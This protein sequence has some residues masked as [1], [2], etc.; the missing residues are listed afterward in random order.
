MGR[1]RIYELA[2][3]LEMSNADLVHKAQSLGL[4]VTNHM[5][6][7]EPD[8]AMRLKRAVEMERRGSVVEKRIGS[9]II[10]R[11]VKR[12]E[13]EAKAAAAAT[14]APGAA[15]SVVE[16][17][18]RHEEL[19]PPPP[20]EEGA[21]PFEEQGRAP[22]LPLAAGGA[23]LGEGRETAPPMAAAAHPGP[24]AIPSTSAGPMA[25]AGTA[26]GKPAAGPVED[27]F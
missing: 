16:A 12:D 19:P 15:G 22:E 23:G 20:S 5:S 8:D 17:L 9:G 21:V 6:A 7:L 18:P 24:A 27:R 3:E 1:K 14:S 25:H 4:P 2:K 11:R 26:A 10:R 13:A